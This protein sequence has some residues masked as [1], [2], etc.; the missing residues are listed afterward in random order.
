[1]EDNLEMMTTTTMKMES[2]RIFQPRS[3][4]QTKRQIRQQFQ[5]S[6]RF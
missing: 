6:Q 4:T 1:V 3:K 5:N 2:L